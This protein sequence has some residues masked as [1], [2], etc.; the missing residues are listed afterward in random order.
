LPGDL[1]GPG[2]ITFSCD[3][4]DL[5]VETAIAGEVRVLVVPLF[6]REGSYREV[7]R[8]VA[9]IAFHSRIED[10]G[11]VYRMTARAGGEHTI[12]NGRRGW[13]WR[14]LRSSRA[15]L[16]P[17]GRRPCPPVRPQRGRLQE[18]R[19]ILGRRDHHP[20]GGEVAAPKHR[21]GGR[22]ERELW[23][24][25]AGNRRSRASSTTAPG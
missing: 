13:T 25:A 24:D 5:V 1:Q 7:W 12:I 17:R 20:G 10:I 22:L 18:V 6:R 16:E 2:A 9:R 15:T 8:E 19:V 11:Q 21:I 4:D 14:R 3:G 23:Y